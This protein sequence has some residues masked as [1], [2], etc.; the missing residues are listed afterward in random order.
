MGRLLQ[1][2]FD[3]DV[4]LKIIEVILVCGP[5][6]RFFWCNAFTVE[7]RKRMAGNEQCEKSQLACCMFVSDQV[8]GF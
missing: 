7:L 8:T 1:G 5:A 3:R 6:Y 2:A 4:S